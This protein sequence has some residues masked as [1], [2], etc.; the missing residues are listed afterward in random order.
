MLPSYASSEFIAFK[1]RYVRPRVVTTVLFGK[2]NLIG[3]ALHAI[4]Q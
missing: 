2:N 4:R 1:H 3:L